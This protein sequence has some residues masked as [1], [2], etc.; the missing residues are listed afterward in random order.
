M[1]AMKGV[2][3][4]LNPDAQI[5]D[6]TH[7]VPPQDIHAGAF[8]LL[9]CYKDFP[10]RT[11]H[12]A[13]VDPG[14]GSSR[15]PLMIE[16]AG[17]FFVGPDNGILSWICEREG[18]WRAIHLQN[19]NFFRHSVST[20]FHGRDIF[21]PV[22]AALSNGIPSSELGA[23]V[24]DIVRLESLKT[25]KTNAGRIEG[26]VIY[27]DRFGNCITNLTREDIAASEA[28]AR[29]KL[30]VNAHEINSFREFF[31]DSRTE[32]EPFCVIGSAGF[33]EIAMK[34]SAAAAML[35]VRRGDR[36]SVAS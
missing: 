23:E 27:I 7:D 12:V 6:I 29:T 36:V 11:I 19:E 13:V 21:A 26:S 20:T 17:Q 24:S 33:L 3:L 28:G 9:A 2:I 8:N 4:S 35:N 14:V 31:S 1:G 16:C 5:V 10:A 32:D 25:K 15:R 34:N 22:A 18:N 30:I